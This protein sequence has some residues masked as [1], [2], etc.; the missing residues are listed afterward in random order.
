MNR[1]TLLGLVV[2]LPLLLAA[3]P[4]PADQVFEGCVGI[5][6]VSVSTGFPDSVETILDGGDRIAGPTRLTGIPIEPGNVFEGCD[7]IAGPSSSTGIPILPGLVGF[8]VGII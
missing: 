5:P 3:T 4:L 6:A 8:P 2:A 1:V 7:R